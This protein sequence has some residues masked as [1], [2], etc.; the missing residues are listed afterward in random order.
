MNWI[1]TPMLRLSAQMM[2]VA[3]F[4]GGVI[5]NNIANVDTPGFHAQDVDFARELQRTQN[6]DT[7]DKQEP[8]VFAVEGLMQRP[9]GNNVNVEREG[10]KLSE[11]Q[12][13]F[14]E[15]AQLVR[16]EFHRLR[17]AITEGSGQ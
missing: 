2:N 5:A 7:T 17:T 10:M 4:R 11:T 9:D 15:A 8:Q 1:D 12:L 3:A 13:E 14:R 6:A 16:L